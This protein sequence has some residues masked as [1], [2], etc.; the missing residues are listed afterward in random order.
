MT[1]ASA[2][3]S[4]AAANVIALVNAQHHRLDD[5]AAHAYT[6]MGPDETRRTLIA[7]VNELAEVW[8]VDAAEQGMTWD[9]YIAGIS[10]GW[11]STA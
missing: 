8:A 11:T 3:N 6:T 2:L 4:D 1:S 10:R 9:D 5:Q 7:A